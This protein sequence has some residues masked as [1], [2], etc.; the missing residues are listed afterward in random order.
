LLIVGGVDTAV[1]EMNEQALA[2][3]N[4][5]KQLVLVPGASHL[6][7]E[8]SALGEG[9]PTRKQWFTRYLR[10]KE[11]ESVFLLSWRRVCEHPPKDLL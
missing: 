8:P 4:V 2:K 11:I 7:E 10:S 6:F 3:L 1:I 9:C 5:D